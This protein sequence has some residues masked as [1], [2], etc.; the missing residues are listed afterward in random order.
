MLL[1]I[2]FDAILTPRISETYGVENAV[3]FTIFVC[4]ISIVFALILVIIDKIYSKE[5]EQE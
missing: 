3:A 5:L 2:S 4:F 1:A